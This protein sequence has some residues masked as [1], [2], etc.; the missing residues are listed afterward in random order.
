MRTLSGDDLSLLSNFADKWLRSALAVFDN[1]VKIATEKSLESVY[2]Y[3]GYAPP[4]IVWCDS[5]F[6]MESAFLAAKEQ[7][8]R[9]GRCLAK[10]DGAII[11]NTGDWEHK[12]LGVAGELRRNVRQCLCPQDWRAVTSSIRD[13]VQRGLS[14]AWRVLALSGINGP[15]GWPC[16]LYWPGGWQDAWW[17]AV[18]DYAQSVCGCSLPVDLSVYE[19]VVVGTSAFVPFENV[20][21]V[22]R[23][24]TCIWVNSDGHLHCDDGSAVCFNNNVDSIYALRGVV[25]PRKYVETPPSEISLAGV[26]REANADVRAAVIQKVGVVRFAKYAD[27]LDAWDGYTLLDLSRMFPIKDAEGLS[28]WPWRKRSMPFLLMDNPSVT[29]VKHLEGVH[30]SCKTVQDA[31]NWRAGNISIQWEPY[32]LS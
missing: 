31:I 8:V 32:Q 30:P 2:E 6:Q 19:H 21:F 9:L 26:L 25:V 22:A 29:G 24:P 13:Y 27:V 4:L 16:Y 3:H 14:G 20:C 28:Q 5:P 10:S 23:K 17:L 18:A 12:E 7:R 11:G 15:R 1:S